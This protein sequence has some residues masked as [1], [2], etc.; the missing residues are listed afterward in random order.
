MSHGLAVRRLI[1]A[2]VTL[3]LLATPVAAQQLPEPTRERPP[4]L[5]PLYIAFA[6]L[7]AID[8]HSTLSAVD[9]GAREMNP[10][11]RGVVGNP[12]VMFVLKTGTAV[13]V[14]LLTEKIW[15]HNRTAALLTMV[16]LNSAYA[17]IAANNYRAR[18][19][20]N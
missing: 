13:G 16:A 15:P 7:Q 18:G 5:L 10:V 3:L 12:A 11:V 2:S 19:G 9:A 20:N 14:V 17:T 4:A 8:A 1:G 6:G